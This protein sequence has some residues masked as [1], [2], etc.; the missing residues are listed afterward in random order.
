MTITRLDESTINA[1]LDAY[2]HGA[3]EGDVSQ[4]RQLHEML[5]LMLTERESPDGQLWLTDHARMLLAEMHR[6][7]SKCE[8]SENQLR[9]KVL[10]AVQLKPAA[11]HWK[12]TCSFVHDL[13]IA[14][15][16]ANELCL[17]RNAGE[18]TDLAAASRAVAEAGEFDL[19]PS[20]IGNIYQEIAATVGGFREISRC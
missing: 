8:G 10:D 2:L 19:T 15:A 6:E 7:L 3:R 12:D 14:T 9:E 16:V 20:A 17:Q 1:S 18:E 4:A 5:D 11:D 13:R